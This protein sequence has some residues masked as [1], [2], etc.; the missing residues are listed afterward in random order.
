[1]RFR[2]RR[3]VSV[4]F[5]LKKGELVWSELSIFVDFCRFFWDIFTKIPQNNEK[6]TTEKSRS[7]EHRKKG[8]RRYSER[9][10][11]RALQRRRRLVDDDRHLTYYRLCVFS[12]FQDNTSRERQSAKKSRG[13]SPRK[14]YTIS[15][16]FRTPRR[17]VPAVLQSQRL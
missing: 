3:R 11:Q 7:N 1:M 10:I 12:T 15:R 9:Y 14:V 4:G 8:T 13:P 17:R 5:S 6:G 2:A 16:C